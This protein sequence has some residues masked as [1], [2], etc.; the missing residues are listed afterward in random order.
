MTWAVTRVLAQTREAR[1][2]ELWAV[3]ALELSETVELVRAAF[4]AGA[5]PKSRAVTRETPRVKSRTV[6]SGVGSM[7]MWSAPWLTKAMRA[8]VTAKA[9]ARPV[10]PPASESSRVSMRLWRTMRPRL[11]P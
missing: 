5:S 2:P 9:R 11:E 8:R 7:A 4:R 1:P 10:A 6:M 3:R